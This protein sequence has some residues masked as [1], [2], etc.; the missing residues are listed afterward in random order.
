MEGHI[1]IVKLLMSRDDLDINVQDRMVRNEERRWN[2]S[3]NNF[4]FSATMHSI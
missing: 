4:I 3:T 2:L 1:E